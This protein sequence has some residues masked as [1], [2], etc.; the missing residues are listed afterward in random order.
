MTHFDEMKG[1]EGVVRSCYRLVEDWLAHTPPTLLEARRAQAELMFRRIGITFAVYGKQEATERLIPFDII[2]RI[3]AAADVM[4][5]P[6]ESEGLAN[7]WVESLACGTPILPAS[8][9]SSSSRAQARPMPRL[10]PVI[11]ALCP[12]R[13]QR[14]VVIKL[15]SIKRIWDE[16]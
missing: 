15:R 2:P 9:R 12:S 13:R 4:A 1:S 16:D 8:G 10:A 7:A 11:R 5:L 6:S 3:F 14:V